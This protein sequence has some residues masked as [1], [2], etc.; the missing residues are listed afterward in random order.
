MNTE[1]FGPVTPEDAKLAEAV[2]RLM[3]GKNLI[4]A[5]K[6][7]ELEMAA[8]MK[9]M[10]EAPKLRPSFDANLE[11]LLLERFAHETQRVSFW[12]YRWIP[13]LIGPLTVAVLAIVVV[14]NPFAEPTMTLAEVQDFEP[15][16]EAENILGFLDADAVT[17]DGLR[18]AD[19]RQAIHD[20]NAIESTTD[21]HLDPEAVL[22][23]H[24]ELRDAAL[25]IIRIEFALSQSLP[26][27]RIAMVDTDL[28]D[29]TTKVSSWPTVNEGV[30]YEVHEK[31]VLTFIEHNSEFDQEMTDLAE[32]IV[33][34]LIWE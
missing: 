8:R 14:F 18:V 3:E 31:A 7:P 22:F 6:T 1:E 2:N 17:E 34:E 32:L 25:E 33:N 5:D 10:G 26:S 29:F 11:S 16:S 9:A 12:K 28:V 24:V 19:L 4:E 13:S 20:I 21:L 23:P 15:L 30:E 27:E